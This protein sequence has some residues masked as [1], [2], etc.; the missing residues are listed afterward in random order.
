MGLVSGGPHDVPFDDGNANL[1][2][3]LIAIVYAVLPFL[4][5]RCEPIA[6]AVDGQ[7][8]FVVLLLCLWLCN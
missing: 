3:L 2:D 6:E 1:D 7:V 8:D 5:H 4:A